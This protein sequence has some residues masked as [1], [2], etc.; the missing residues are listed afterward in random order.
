VKVFT[1]HGDEV[2]HLRLTVSAKDIE[3]QDLIG[4]LIQ[5]SQ[6]RLGYY[7]TS[8]GLCIGNG[9]AVERCQIDAREALAKQRAEGDRNDPILTTQFRPEFSGARV[10]AVIRAIRE[11]TGVQ[12]V[13]DAPTWQE[14]KT[15]TWS[16]D[17]MPLRDALDKICA[18]LHVVYRVRGGRVFL[19]K[20]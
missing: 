20:P 7:V 18:E 15:L 13:T 3:V 19:C 16:A 8:Q 6:N 12:V 9:R 11:Q 4:L 5:A 14:A 17:P 2:A 1:L 10:S